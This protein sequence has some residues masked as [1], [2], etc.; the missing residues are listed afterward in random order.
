MNRHE[1]GTVPSHTYAPLSGTVD[2]GWRVDRL[3]PPLGVGSGPVDA[4]AAMRP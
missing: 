2:A 1:L 4:R 3:S